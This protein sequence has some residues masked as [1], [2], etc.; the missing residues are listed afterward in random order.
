M[1]LICVL[2]ILRSV[3]FP[4]FS[5]DLPFCTTSKKVYATVFLVIKA[6]SQ[7]KSELQ[8]TS[9]EL[10]RLKKKHENILEELEEERE[11]AV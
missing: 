5:K 8:K 7:L 11:V 10:E 9:A 2:P 4:Q 3:S 1:T 6:S